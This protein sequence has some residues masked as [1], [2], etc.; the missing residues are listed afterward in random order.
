MNQNLTEVVFILDR[1]GS[2]HGLEKDTVGGFNA[3]IEEQKGK[4]GEVLIS[5]VLFN[6]SSTVLHDRV[7]IREVRE[8]TDRDYRTSG[9]TALLDAIGDAVRHIRNVHKYIRQEDVPA[10]TMFVI[11]TDG[12]ENASREYT[13]QEVRG[14]IREQEE[15]KGWEFLFLGA[16]IDAVETAQHFGIRPD[17]AVDY[18]NDDKGLETNYKAVS[19]AVTSMRECGNVDAQWSAPI[20]ADY[21]KRKRR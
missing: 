17:R 19:Y 8:M 6:G 10:H 3:M 14:M 13:A 4:E 11:T 5:T 16:N 18:L 1:S 20:K 2:M 12:M 9:C 7:P 15:Q 21:K